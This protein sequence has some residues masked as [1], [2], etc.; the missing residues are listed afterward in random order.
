MSF[1][2]TSLHFLNT[3]RDGDSS[4][5]PGSLFQYLTSLSEN[6]ISNLNLPWHNLRPLLLVLGMGEVSQAGGDQAGRNSF[7]ESTQCVKEA[8]CSPFTNPPSSLLGTTSR[9]EGR[10]CHL[11]APYW[12]DW[13]GTSA[14]RPGFCRVET[15]GGCSCWHH[16]TRQVCTGASSLPAFR[17]LWEVWGWPCM[18][19]D[20]LT[21]PCGGIHLCLEVGDTQESLPAF[22][23]HSSL[24][25]IPEFS[26][27]RGKMLVSSGTECS[28]TVSQ[29]DIVARVC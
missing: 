15:H 26:L 7:P 1:S 13:P 18:G 29:P 9:R 5:S 22:V 27:V 28:P 23:I 25:E 14:G 24:P 19:L 2:A 12:E 3:S 16:V 6:L 17:L 4:T 20:A 8:M 10:D 21:C 11:Q